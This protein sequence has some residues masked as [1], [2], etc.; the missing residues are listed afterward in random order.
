MRKAFTMIELLVVLVIIG[1][2]VALILP[3][4]L[5]AVRVGNYRA[6]AANLRSIDT[7]AQLCYAET[8][9]WGQCNTLA[10][11]QQ[12]FPDN[13]LPTCPYGVQYTLVQLGP[14]RG[15]A[16]NK[17]AHFPNW[18]DITCPGAHVP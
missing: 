11:L 6:C 7:A 12:Y 3:N 8:G 10:Q 1:I 5:R 17:Q 15:W 16:S 2:L 18:P 13:V 9:D 14:G 4:S